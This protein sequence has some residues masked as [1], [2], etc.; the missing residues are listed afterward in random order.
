MHFLNPFIAFFIAFLVAL[1][2][3]VAKESAPDKLQKY[4]CGNFSWLFGF[5]LQMSKEVLQNSVI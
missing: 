3:S 5:Y 4:P 2:T 1:V